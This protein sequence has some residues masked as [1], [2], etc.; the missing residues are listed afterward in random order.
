MSSDTNPLVPMID[1]L[2][3]QTTLSDEDRA[4]LCDMPHRFATVAGG[5]YIIREGDKAENCCV[6]LSG[7]AYRSRIA[8]DGSRQIL[9]FHMRGDMADL[10]NSMMSVADHSVQT[11]TRSEVAYIPHQAIVEI[12]AQHP[13]IGRALWRQTLIE[14]SIAHEWMVNLGQRNA[15]QR[16][17]HFICEMALL[18]KAA[19]L[20]DGPKCAWPMTQ[21]QVADAVGLTSVHVNRT[22]QGLRGD[23]IISINRH[24]LTINDW[25]ALRRAGDF[26][27]AYLHQQLAA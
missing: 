10:Q 17:S 22:M 24:V 26:R 27:A 11:L 19:R 25:E 13:T 15:R 2:A 23:G 8:G 3:S 4:A 12:A 16:V 18:Q 21:E 5:A 1:K 9:A 7:F 14:A 6:I 20:T